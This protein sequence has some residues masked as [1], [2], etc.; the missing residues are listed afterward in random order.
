MVLNHQPW[1]FVAAADFLLF[2]PHYVCHG[3]IA[4]QMF[5]INNCVALSHCERRATERSNPEN[6]LILGL[7]RSSQ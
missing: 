6:K 4:P 3:V 1:H 7:L 5:F 2:V